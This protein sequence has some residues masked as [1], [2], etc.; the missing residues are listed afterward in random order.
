MSINL[1]LWSINVLLL[2]LDVV[3]LLPFID[4]Y[5]LLVFTGRQHSLQ[6]RCPVC[7]LVCPTLLYCAK[8]MQ[9]KM[10]TF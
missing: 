5:R 10:T 6:C 2:Q 4:R 3:Q 8:T 1:C 9:T 7:P